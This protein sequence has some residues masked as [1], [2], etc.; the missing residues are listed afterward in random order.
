MGLPGTHPSG[1]IIAK[2]GEAERIVLVMD[3][4]A[5]Q[6]AWELVKRLGKE[7]CRVLIPN[8]KV[9]D[10]VLE[11]GMGARDLLY[12]LRNALPAV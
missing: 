1:D 8:M 4:D 10:A 11:S 6:P 5:K 9:D 2:L 7:R 12:L 3:P